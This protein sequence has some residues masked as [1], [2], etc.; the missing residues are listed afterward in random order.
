MSKGSLNTGIFDVYSLHA[1]PFPKV[2]R[3]GR[4][5]GFSWRAVSVWKTK[6]HSRVFIFAWDVTWGEVL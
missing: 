2:H 3:N 4:K 5:S 6:F 1:L